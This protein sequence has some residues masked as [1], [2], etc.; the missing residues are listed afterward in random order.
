MQEYFDD[1]LVTLGDGLLTVEGVKVAGSRTFRRDPRL[2]SLAQ[3]LMDLPPR[4]KASHQG[5]T[6]PGMKWCSEADHWEA[7]D[8]FS[9]DPRYIDGKKPV[10]KLCCARNERRRYAL[11]R[12]AQGYTVKPYGERKRA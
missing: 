2:G 3:A 8:E 4:R 12:E 7:R 11:M 9:A 1:S 10:C 6:M 5:V